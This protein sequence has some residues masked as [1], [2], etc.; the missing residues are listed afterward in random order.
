M[1]RQQAMVILDAALAGNYGYGLRVGE[2]DLHEAQSV[3][4]QRQTDLRKKL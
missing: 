1:P 3:L 4:N 2:S